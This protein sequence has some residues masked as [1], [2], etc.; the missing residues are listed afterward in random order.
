MEN[1]NSVLM[2][3]KK[4]LQN[5]SSSDVHVRSTMEKE[6]IDINYALEKWENGQFGIC[7][8][9]GKPIPTEWLT[10]I[11]TIRT[12]DDWWEIKQYYRKPIPFI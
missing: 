5:F 2:A 10:V 11:P 7:E 3:L 1:I 4:D 8:C 6:L 12:M 9:C